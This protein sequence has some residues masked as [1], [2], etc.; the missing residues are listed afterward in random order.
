M[1]SIGS[2]LGSA[3]SALQ[4]S[5]LGIS[6]ASNNIANS[7]NLQYTRQ[8]LITAPAADLLGQAGGLGVQVLGV[9]SIR[10]ALIEKRL[11]QEDASQGGA[12]TLSRLLSNIEPLFT[13]SDSTGLQQYISDFFNSFQTL[14]T[15]PSSSSFRQIVRTRAE[16]LA[17]A[18]SRT[19]QELVQSQADANT[20]VSQLVT[21]I[22]ALAD[23]IAAVTGQIA[24]AG[25]ESSELRDQRSSL[26]RELASIAD[27][28]ELDNGDTYQLT[29]GGNRLLVLGP[30]NFD[31]GT[32]VDSSG[33]THVYSET[34]DITAEIAIGGLAAQLQVR[35]KYVPDYLAQL[36]ELAYNIV[37][38]VN[39][40]HSDGFDLDGNTG[41][42]FFMSL[43]GPSGAA[44]LMTVSSAVSANLRRIA[45]SSE[46]SG[47]GNQV[48]IQIGNLIFE[49]ATPV[50]SFI[51]Q[52]QHLVF[53]VATD[54]SDAETSLREH[55][56][57]ATQL[58]ARRQ[59][60]SGVSIDEES[61]QLLQFQRAYE[62]SAKLIS[63]V[64][65]MLRVV[66]GIGS[67]S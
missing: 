31:L 44:G 18:F 66:L 17:G 67:S 28:H 36:D 9:E 40:R 24:Q 15:D 42:D 46:A 53:R 51:N 7:S 16:A 2:I 5:Q 26:V 12:D 65:E 11:I 62:A 8:R 60:V 48:A 1:S 54:L 41:I 34:D 58:E 55:Q 6:V 57:L 10:D 61:V 14:S 49:N 20:A 39:S 13:D 37:Q 21:R 29:V 19:R 45:P 23:R 59:G 63:A 35:D 3:L 50:G 38:Q 4:A 22:N 30:K 32:E 33:F 47:L 64:D 52:Y 43:A 56:A 25:G 27:V